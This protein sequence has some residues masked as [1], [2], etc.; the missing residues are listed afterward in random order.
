M[1]N[2]PD[3]SNGCGVLFRALESE[4]DLRFVIKSWV[5]SYAKSPWAGAISRP[6]LVRAIKETILDI[7]QRPNAHIMMA[8]KEGGDDS[9]NLLFGFACFETGHDFPLLHYV[10]VKGGLRKCGIGGDLR[11][12]ALSAGGKGR[13]RYTFRTPSSR[14]FLRGAKFDPSLVR[15]TRE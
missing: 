13:A 1:T 6:L 7:M 5:R 11:D 8:C 9:R 3:Q 10:Y 4:D 12:L 2:L 14:Q 15:R